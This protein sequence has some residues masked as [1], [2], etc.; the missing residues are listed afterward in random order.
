MHR[1][2]AD[3]ADFHGSRPHDRS[4][5]RRRFVKSDGAETAGINL[6]SLLSLHRDS[7][8]SDAEIIAISNELIKRN[9]EAYKEACV[10]IFSTRLH[11]CATA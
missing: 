10:M 8:L 2:F 6:E 7:T 9:C 5:D 3:E 11:N 4:D 1:C